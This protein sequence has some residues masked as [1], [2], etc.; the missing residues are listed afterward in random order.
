LSLS[1]YAIVFLFIT[2]Q[3]L[4]RLGLARDPTWSDSATLA[5]IDERTGKSL[6]RFGR[7]NF[8]FELATLLAAEQRFSLLSGRMA[9]RQ[10]W[11]LVLF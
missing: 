8:Y 3:V 2:L 1:E 6:Q 9:E 7:E 5:L 4:A 11:R 10:R